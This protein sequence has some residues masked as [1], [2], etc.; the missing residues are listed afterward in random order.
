MHS[1]KGSCEIYGYDFML[2]EGPEGP[3]VW[4]LEVNRSPS[5]GYHTKVK[6]PLVRQM[7]EDTAKVMADLKDDPNASTGEWELIKH[8]YV[9]QVVGKLPPCPA[10]TLAQLTVVGTGM[11]TLKGPKRQGK[12]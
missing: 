7:M 3:K 9:D 5:V 1:R 2:A 4:L 8:P 11:Q 10:E 6:A 12:R